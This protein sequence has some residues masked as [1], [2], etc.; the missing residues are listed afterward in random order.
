VA[1]MSREMGSAVEALVTSMLDRLST[2]AP[3]QNSF[4]Q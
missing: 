4:H 3:A 2:P 1:G